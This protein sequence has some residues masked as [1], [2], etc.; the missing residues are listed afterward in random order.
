[1]AI[2]TWMFS[3]TLGMA[4]LSHG[5]AMRVRS[6]SRVWIST[7]L[8]TVV[9]LVAPLSAGGIWAGNLTVEAVVN[10]INPLVSTEFWDPG[11]PPL[12]GALSVLVWSA[13]TVALFLSN[14]RQLLRRAVEA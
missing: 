5:M 13:L 8:W 14:G 11:A 1:M 7:A 10:L 12:L 3:S 9:L 4:A 6:A 2:T